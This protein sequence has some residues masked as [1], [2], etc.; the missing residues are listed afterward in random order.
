MAVEHV[1]SQI[2]WLFTSL[3]QKVNRMLDCEAEYGQLDRKSVVRSLKSEKVH[4]NHKILQFFDAMFLR[5]YK[6]PENL[7]P[8]SCEEKS[9]V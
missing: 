7:E 9:Y 8:N 5:V 3:H 4:T 1:K 6:F 2:T